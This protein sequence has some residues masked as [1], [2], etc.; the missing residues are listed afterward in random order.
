MDLGS[1]NKT[2]INVSGFISV[3]FSTCK[4]LLIVSLLPLNIFFVLFFETFAVIFIK[5]FL[6]LLQE[7]AIEPQ[8]YYELKEQ[9]TIKFGNSR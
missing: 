5:H 4:N 8:R 2:F 3:S 7:T 1:T 9:D 6:L